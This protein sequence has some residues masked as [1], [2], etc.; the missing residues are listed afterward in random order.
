MNSVHGP[1][2]VLEQLIN[3]FELIS[4]ATNVFKSRSFHPKI[5]LLIRQILS[6]NRR[7]MPTSIKIDTDFC[8]ARP[9]PAFP[10]VAKYIETMYGNAQYSHHSLCF[11]RNVP[12]TIH[13]S[14]HKQ[15]D[16][17]AAIYSDHLNNLH[18]GIIIGIIQLKPANNLIFIIDQA[19][20]MGFDSFSADGIQYVNDF[21][22]YAKHSSPPNMV[23]IGYN[24]IREK[25]AYR[26]DAKMNAFSQFYIFPNLVE[27]T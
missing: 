26:K 12:F 8:L 13:R 1:S 11:Y 18:I 7:A 14:T 10:H 21:L 25:V 4:H 3:N 24:S 27:E 6:S 15:V 23:S 2:L 19:D 22:V 17:S 16:N 20:I 5:A 9:T